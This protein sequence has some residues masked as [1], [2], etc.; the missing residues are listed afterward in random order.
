MLNEAMHICLLFQGHTDFSHHTGGKCL[1]STGFTEG[2]SVC[3]GACGDLSLHMGQVVW[4]CA[5]GEEEPL[6]KSMGVLV[7]TWCTVMEGSIF[8]GGE[9]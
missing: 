3:R 1:W 2:D 6:P 4:W 9:R 7:A 5:L 8:S